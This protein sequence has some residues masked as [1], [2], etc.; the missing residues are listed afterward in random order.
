MPQR[1][2]Y[3]LNAGLTVRYSDMV[4]AQ[5][6]FEGSGALRI[7]PTGGRLVVTSRTYNQTATGTYGQFVPGLPEDQAIVYGAQGRL[8]QLSQ[9]TSTTTGYR[10]NVGFV[11][12][13][14]MPIHVDAQLFTSTGAALGTVGCDLQAY[15]YQQIDR[16][17]TKVPAASVADGFA[18]LKTTT[19]G[20]RFFAYA[21]V[22]DNATGD[23]VCV[24]VTR[25]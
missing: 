11:N 13:T 19:T 17:F 10:T 25:R 14:N 22:I 16:I 24:Q 8:V 18:V 4:L 12:A 15:D 23:P 7:T 9:S 6:S 1:V 21:S 20:G 2:T 3:N 5:F